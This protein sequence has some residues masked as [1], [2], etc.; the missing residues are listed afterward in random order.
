MKIKSIIDAGQKH[1]IKVQPK[2]VEDSYLGLA[3]RRWDLP[4]HLHK[5]NLEQIR[6]EFSSRM[7]TDYTDFIIFICV[8]P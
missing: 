2:T 1:T 7:N 8:Y 6:Q 5:P 4:R 3:G